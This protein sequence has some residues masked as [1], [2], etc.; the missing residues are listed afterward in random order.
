MW[1]I[2]D[3]T[4]DNLDLVNGLGMGS[5]EEVFAYKYLDVN[6]N[7]MS[8][9]GLNT[10]V[11]DEKAKDPSYEYCPKLPKNFL[12]QIEL[13]ESLKIDSIEIIQILKESSDVVNS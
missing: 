13:L 6:T 5:H 7:T 1:I 9:H 2:C 8:Y 12:K 4:K 3:N 11:T 10:S